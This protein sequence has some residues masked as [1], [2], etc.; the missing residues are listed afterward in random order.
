MRRPAFAI[1]FLKILSSEYR[2]NATRFER[3][4][5]RVVEGLASWQLMTRSHQRS[6]STVRFQG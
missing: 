6:I 4:E 2:L 1:A 5:S 3:R